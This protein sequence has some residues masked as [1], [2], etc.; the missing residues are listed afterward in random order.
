MK[1]ITRIRDALQFAPKL[2][3]LMLTFYLAGLLNGKLIECMKGLFEKPRIPEKL[4]NI[5]KLKDYG[6]WNYNKTLANW[7]N[8][9]KDNRSKRKDLNKKKKNE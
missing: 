7:I 2:S 6:L 3:V 9:F 4:L 1:L 8:D 5:Y